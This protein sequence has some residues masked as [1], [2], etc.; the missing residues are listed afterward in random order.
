MPKSNIKITIE[1]DGAHFAGWQVQ[2]NQVTVQ[3]ELEKALHNLTQNAIKVI[4][5]GRTDAGVHALGQVASFEGKGGLPLHA[6]RDGMNSFLLPSIRIIKAEYVPESF[7]ARYNAKSRTY[8]YILTKRERA[9]G[10]QYAWFPHFEFSLKRMKR[11]SKYLM[12]EH[13]F[14]SFCKVGEE[15]GEFISTIHNIHW[16][17]FNEEIHFEIRAVR[18]FH[19]MVRIVLGTL[20][21]VGRGK[22]S[23]KDFRSILEA[24]DRR[25][26]GPTIPPNG[27]YLLRVDY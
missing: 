3:G 19:N 17:D 5:A 20:L 26:A 21:D 22:L 27:L 1:Y 24:K 4:G 23:E 10:F 13:C 18:F 25:K 12:G 16:C 9:I 6:Y 14:L 8:R 11:A 15:A 7:N 2:P